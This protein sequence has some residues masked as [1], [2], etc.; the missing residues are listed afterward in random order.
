MA[1]SPKSVVMS[2][3][4]PR[5]WSWSAALLDPVIGAHASPHGL[6]SLLA[7]NISSTATSQFLLLKN[8]DHQ[9]NTLHLRTAW[10]TFQTGFTQTSSTFPWP[11]PR[12]R[13]RASDCTFPVR[14]IPILSTAP[15]KLCYWKYGWIWWW[16]SICSV[17][18]QLG[19]QGLESHVEMLSTSPNFAAEEW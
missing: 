4:Q 12:L 13:H 18:R 3:P 19:K 6:T 11:D 17:F 15:E 16:L 2:C 9:L 10:L 8:I 14:S 7:L 1:T 5:D